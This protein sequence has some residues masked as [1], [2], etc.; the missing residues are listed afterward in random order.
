[1][2]F[3]KIAELPANQKLCFEHVIKCWKTIGLQN[4]SGK[5]RNFEIGENGITLNL[6]KFGIVLK[7]NKG[8]YSK[9]LLNNRVNY[10]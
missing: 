6:D 9:K 8:F 2:C 4:R 3:V 1:M 5:W 10:H 7:V